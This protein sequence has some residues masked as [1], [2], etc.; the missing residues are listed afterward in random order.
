[1]PSTEPQASVP[2]PRPH[3]QSTDTLLVCPIEKLTAKCEAGGQ[4]GSDGKRLSVPVET[5]WPEGDCDRN[6]VV[7][8]RTAEKTST[9]EAQRKAEKEEAV[10]PLTARPPPLLPRPARPVRRL[11]QQKFAVISTLR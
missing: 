5:V 6:S 9:V 3:S 2:R 8:G 4:D 11:R 7:S 1:M 10:A